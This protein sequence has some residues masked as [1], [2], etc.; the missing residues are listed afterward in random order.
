M[1]W[2]AKGAVLRCI[3]SILELL[4]RTPRGLQFHHLEREQPKAAIEF[5]RQIDPALAAG[6][7]RRQVQAERGV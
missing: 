6:V 7:L 4:Q 2:L 1:D 5:Q 3:N